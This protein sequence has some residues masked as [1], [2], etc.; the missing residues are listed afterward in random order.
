M[1][2]LGAVAVV[3]GYLVPELATWTVDRLR[4]AGAFE[5][6]SSWWCQYVDSPRRYYQLTLVVLVLVY[7]GLFFWAM[8]WAMRPLRDVAT[9]LASIGP[10]NF[11]H[12]LAASRRSGEMIVLARAVNDMLDRLA[13]GYEAQR[14]FAADASHE[15][16]TPLAV[17]RTLIE[18]GLAGRPSPEKL[19]VLTEQLLA[20]NERNVRLI[21]AL[22]VLAESDRGLVSRS[23]LRLDM[24]VGRMIEDHRVPAADAGLTITSLLQPRTVVGEQALLERL[25]TNLLQNAIKYNRPGGMIDVRVGDRPALVVVNTGDDVPVEAVTGLFEPFR[26]LAGSRIGR[27]G[28]VGLGLTIVRS[29]VQAHDGTVACFSTGH[30]GLR[31]E[32]T[33]P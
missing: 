4:M 9:A 5:C 30:D 8:R 22:L 33:L 14:R 19:E 25:V 11:G 24:I 21:E 29:I 15:L 31:F 27:S 18:V 7:L 3:A 6:T 2:L 20:A 16:R 1:L 10:Q 13:A 26:R 17:Q 32:I 12:R 23:E 28:G